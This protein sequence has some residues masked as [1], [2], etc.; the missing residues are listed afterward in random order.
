[1]KADDMIWRIIIWFPIPKTM[2][3]INSQE[4][5]LLGKQILPKSEDFVFWRPFWIQ[6]GRHSKLKWSPY[7]AACL[8]PCKYPF[9][10]KSFHLWIFNNLLWFFNFYIGSHFVLPIS[11]FWAYLDSL[12]TR[13]GC[14]KKHYCKNLWSLEWI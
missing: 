10:F 14:D 5:R 12:D 9:P 2:M 13:Y 4:Q 7:G 6:N 8:T 1:M 11:I 3:I